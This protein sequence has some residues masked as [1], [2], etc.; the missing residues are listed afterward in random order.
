MNRLSCFPFLRNTFRLAIFAT[1][2]AADMLWKRYEH[3]PRYGLIK[4]A[5]AA[6]QAKLNLDVI[7]LYN[8]IYQAKRQK[9]IK[10]YDHYFFNCIECYHFADRF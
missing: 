7:K 6:L 5:Q 4:I 3:V 1:P 10:H 2:V 9:S 8:G